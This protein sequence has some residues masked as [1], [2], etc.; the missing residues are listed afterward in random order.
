MNLKL[1]QEVATPYWPWSWR[2]F[3]PKQREVLERSE[4]FRPPQL[5]LCTGIILQAADACAQDLGV[6]PKTVR[7]WR[8]R[9]AEGGGPAVGPE[10]LADAQCSGAQA[11]LKS[12]RVRY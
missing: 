10:R 5:A 4:P 2:P 7:Y 11:D 6:W 1:E 3:Y 9:R 8:K 12:H